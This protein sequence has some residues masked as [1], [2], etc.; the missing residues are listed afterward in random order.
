MSGKAFTE[1]K[2]RATRA[3]NESGDPSRMSPVLQWT[4]VIIA[5]L[6]VMA[7]IFYFGRDVRSDLGGGHSG[8]PVD[9]AA[10][11]IDAPSS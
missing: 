11:V 4:L 10:V 2:G 8:A 3:R 7:A 6:A 5:G 1:P 9:V